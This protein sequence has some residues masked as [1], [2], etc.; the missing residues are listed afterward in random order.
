MKK[1][2]LFLSTIPF[3]LG[4][5]A[6]EAYVEF[7]NQLGLGSTL[8]DAAECIVRGGNGNNIICGIFGEDLDFDPTTGETVIDPLGNPDIFVASYANDNTLEWA[9]HLGRIGLSDGMFIGGMDVDGEGNILIGGHFSLTVD[10]DPSSE[11]ANLISEGGSDAFLAKYDEGGNLIW[12]RSMGSSGSESITEVEVTAENEIIIGLRFSGSV[13]VDPSVSEVLLTPVGGFDAAIVSYAGDGQYQWS[14]H[15]QPGSENEIIHAIAGDQEGNLAIGASIAGTSEGIPEQSMWF[16]LLDQNGSTVWSYDFDNQ[17]QSNV[18]SNLTYSQDGAFLYIGGRVRSVTDFDPGPG[19]RIISPLF[20]D[21]FVAKY[22]LTDGSLVWANR[23]ESPSTEDYCAGLKE[24]NGLVYMAGTF[25]VSAN[26]V[27]G[28]FSTQIASNGDRD[29]YLSVYDAESGD[30]ISASHFGGNGG[31]LVKSAY[32]TDDGDLLTT[33]EFLNS[34]GLDPESSVES[35]GFLD[36]FLGEFEYLYN[37]SAPSLLTPADLKVYPV[38]SPDKIYIELPQA[39]IKDAAIK[40]VNVVGQSVLDFKNLEPQKTH[41]I[42]ISAL[43]PGVYIV[44]VSVDGSKVSKR[45]IKE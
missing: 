23:I 16:A 3:Y 18:I 29:M 45:L 19:E 25:D 8:N 5:F 38:P 15:I 37:L 17:G 32:F 36:I 1:Y 10:F 22:A 9:F 4:T 44:E 21:P 6:Q 30:F 24:V 33:G 43:K 34:L 7:S 28:D 13:D 12:A 20:A 31:E 42:D 35:E 11:T 40:I 41:S 14:E 39:S 26:F 2:L 27:P